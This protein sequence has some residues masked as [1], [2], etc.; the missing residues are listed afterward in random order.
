MT[1]IPKG[2]KLVDA[3]NEESLDRARSCLMEGIH[4]L[5]EV[6]CRTRQQAIIL[7]GKQLV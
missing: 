6:S 1:S 4:L 2:V 3:S 5:N 7:F